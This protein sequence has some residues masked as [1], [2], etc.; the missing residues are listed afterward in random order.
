MRHLAYLERYLRRN[1]ADAARRVE[2]L[3]LIE[4]VKKTTF[5]VEEPFRIVGVDL[6]KPEYLRV[7][8]GGIAKRVLEDRL[9]SHPTSRPSYL[10]WKETNARRLQELENRDSR[11]HPTTLEE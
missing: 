6:N 4:S 2:A 10:T 3:T 5:V 1:R 9:S 8:Q 7:K 11:E